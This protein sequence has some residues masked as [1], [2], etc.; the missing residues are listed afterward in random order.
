[1]ALSEMQRKCA[2]MMIES[3]E[4]SQ[5]QLADELGVHRNTIGNWSR[6]KEFLA[7]KNDMAMDVHK[8]FLADTLKVLREKT[9]DPKARSHVRYLELALKSYGL[10]TDRVES[11]VTVKEEKSEQDLLAELMGE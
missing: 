1:M 7:Y 9:L 11:S 6:N 2:L 5:I 10:L 3:P 8:S 4:L